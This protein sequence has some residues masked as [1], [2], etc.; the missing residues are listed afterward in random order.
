[1]PDRAA[2]VLEATLRSGDKE[3][4]QR[5]LS[6]ASMMDSST[7]RPLLVGALRD[8][9]PQVATQ[10]AQQLG[11]VGG[12]DAQSALVDVITQSASPA[13]VRMA[14]AEALDRMG[15]AAAARYRDLID[16]IKKTTVPPGGPT[17][18]IEDII[19]TV[20]KCP[21]G[22]SDDDDGCPDQG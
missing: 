5:A 3:A 2:R 20:D 15:G 4:R 12:A 7:V 22:G 14:A 13:D 16:Q 18:V 8:E 6:A 17:A 10:A 11:N 9:D 19:D 1:E 21:E